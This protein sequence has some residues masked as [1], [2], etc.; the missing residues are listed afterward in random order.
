VESE[1][2]TDDAVLN[3]V[4]KK[5]DIFKLHARPCLTDFLTPLLDRFSRCVLWTSG[6]K[7]VSRVFLTAVCKHIHVFIFMNYFRMYVHVNRYNTVSKTATVC[8]TFI[9][10]HFYTFRY[11]ISLKVFFHNEK[12]RRWLFI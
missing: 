1:G 3:I 6:A 7:K 8:I 11:R 9:F 2:S 12:K 5:R 10:Q 4:Q